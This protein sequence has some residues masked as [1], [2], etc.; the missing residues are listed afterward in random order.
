MMHYIHTND[1]HRGH[2]QQ[3]KGNYA[4]SRYGSKYITSSYLLVGMVY[5]Y[6]S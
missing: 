3:F 2:F 5:V 6:L 1:I 4:I